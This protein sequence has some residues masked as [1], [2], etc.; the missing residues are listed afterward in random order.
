[1][2]LPFHNNLTIDDAERV[3]D[4]LAKSLVATQ[5]RTGG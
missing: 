1:L 4:A 5:A 3:V 2:R